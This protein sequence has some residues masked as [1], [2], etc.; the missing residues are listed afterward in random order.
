MEKSVLD[1]A[2]DQQPIRK[3]VGHR[4]SP[5]RLTGIPCGPSEALKAL[6][7]ENAARGTSRVPKGIFRYRSHEEA[8]R[9]W[10]RWQAQAIAEQQAKLEPQ[11]DP[12][13]GPSP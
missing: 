4:I 8:N 9:D 5:A 1:P 10:D 11:G 2:L 7:Q 13:L 12:D 3:V 6:L